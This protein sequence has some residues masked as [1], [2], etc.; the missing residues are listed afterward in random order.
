MLNAET[1]NDLV[2]RSDERQLLWKSLRE[3]A[4]RA[5]IYAA[6]DLPEIELDPQVLALLI[7]IQGFDKA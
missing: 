3:R 5:Q 7:G 6:S 4:S 2:V 1:V